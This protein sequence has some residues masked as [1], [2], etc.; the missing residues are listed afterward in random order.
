MSARVACVPVL[1]SQPTGVNTFPAL[2]SGTLTGV[3]AAGIGTSFATS[4]GGTIS[5]VYCANPNGLVWL[6]Y[7]CGTTGTGYQV[8][9]GEQLGPGATGLYQP[10]TANAGTIA[11][12]SMG[13]LGPWSPTVYN[14]TANAPNVT[15]T[16]ATNATALVAAVAGCVVIDFAVTTDLEVRFYATNPVF[17]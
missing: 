12:S 15:Y 1:F 6:Y 17:P 4:W 7:N 9:I 8:L 2:N 10:A 16:G 3:D 11:A 14:Q 5:G 13:W